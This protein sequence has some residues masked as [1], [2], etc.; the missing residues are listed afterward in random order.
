MF[1]FCIFSVVEPEVSFM[2]SFSWPPQVSSIVEYT[3]NQC[4]PV[5]VKERL[6]NNCSFVTGSSKY[7]SNKSRHLLLKSQNQFFRNWPILQWHIFWTICAFPGHS[8]NVFA[9]IC[10]IFDSNTNILIW[11]GLA[12]FAQYHVFGAKLSLGMYIAYIVFAF[13]RLDFHFSSCFM[14]FSL[15]GREKI[16]I[17]L[18]PKKKINFS[19]RPRMNFCRQP[20]KKIVS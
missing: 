19:D 13:L 9:H 4:N 7:L 16:D 5:L 15:A 12:W 2:V 3:F 20:K 18:L 8:E 1:R 17:N 14:H 11:K 10:F 6:L